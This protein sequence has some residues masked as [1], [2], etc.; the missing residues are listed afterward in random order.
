MSRI[1]Q[2]IQEDSKQVLSGVNSVE[3]SYLYT[4]SKLLID[5]N[6]RALL[7]SVV[8]GDIIW[9]MAMIFESP[10]SNIIQK[11]VTVHTDGT[12]AIFEDSDNI[13]GMYCIISYLTYK[14]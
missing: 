1:R 5:D 14:E 9:N 8:V 12:Y 2:L 4:T 10:T 3:N 11:E 13:K 7:P 6:N